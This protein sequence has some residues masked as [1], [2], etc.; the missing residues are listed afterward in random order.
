MIQLIVPA[1]RG[2]L[3]DRMAQAIVKIARQNQ[4]TDKPLQVTHRP[5][6]AVGTLTDSLHAALPGS[7]CLLLVG[8][9]SYASMMIKRQPGWQTLK[10][11]ARLAYEDALLWVNANSPCSSLPQWAAAMGR[12]AATPMVG[13]DGSNTQ[14][15]L[16]W[17]LLRAALQLDLQYIPYQ[18]SG[19]TS[20]QLV[21]QRIEAHVNSA[22]EEI[23]NWL[24][25]RVKPLCVF[26]AQGRDYT[27]GPPAR[28]SAAH[29]PSAVVQGVDV[30]YRATY[31][32]LAPVD[33]PARDVAEGA[34]LLAKVS[35]TDDWQAFLASERLNAGY[36]SPAQFDEYLKNDFDRHAALLSG[37]QVQQES[38]GGSDLSRANG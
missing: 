10:A 21:D 11:V 35:A 7:L 37:R 2:R 14:D 23:E 8:D 34:V 38:I 18:G 12:A 13:G 17:T 6:S 4:L 31:G 26:S 36:L 29:V 19:A 3:L 22:G 32:V 28:I 1:Q 27:L 9:R 30:C 33:C 16:L 24:A 5:V 20:V 15:H 25:G